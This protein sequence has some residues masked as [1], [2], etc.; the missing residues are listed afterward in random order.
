M[1]RCGVNKVL[2]GFL[3]ASAMEDTRRSDNVDA[4]KVLQRTPKKKEKTKRVADDGERDDEVRNQR[5]P[6]SNW[7][8][9]KLA[10]ALPVSK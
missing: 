1:R 6:N 4:T 2:T 5:S 10:G 7:N 3:T 9:S 8:V